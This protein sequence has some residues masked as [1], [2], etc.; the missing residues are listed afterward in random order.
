MR[1]LREDEELYRSIW[2]SRDSAS[3]IAEQIRFSVSV[4]NPLLANI[5]RHR[6][7]IH[8]VELDQLIQSVVNINLL[9]GQL[10]ADL[11][12]ESLRVL[13]RDL[14]RCRAR[15]QSLCERFLALDQRVNEGLT[16]LHGYQNE[17][18]R[19]WETVKG[20]PV[21]HR[22]VNDIRIRRVRCSDRGFLHLD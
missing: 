10:A 1:L 17:F 20:G 9:L 12:Y 16:I 4:M 3:S 18:I 2:L 8:N 13:R 22:L 15:D 14:I 6:R 21:D 7:P 5:F 19:I 11:D